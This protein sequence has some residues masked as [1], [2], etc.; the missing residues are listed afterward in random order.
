MIKGFQNKEDQTLE[1]ITGVYGEPSKRTKRHEVI[2]KMNKNLPYLCDK[3]NKEIS[4]LW[5]TLVKDLNENHYCFQCRMSGNKNPNR[6]RSA[7]QRKISGQKAAK[8]RRKNGYYESDVFKQSIK[9]WN[10]AGIK[11]HKE[12]PSKRK[13]LEVSREPDVCLECGKLV[14]GIKQH[15]ATH[16]ISY[17][18]YAI[19]HDIDEL[20]FCNICNKPYI[21]KLYSK[22]ASCSNKECIRLMRLKINR[23]IN[24][25]SETTINRL[26]SMKRNN[27]YGKSKPEET[28]FKFL[29]SKVE[30]ERQIFFK[31]DKTNHVIDFLVKINN[32]NVFIMQDSSYWHGLNRT[33]EEIQKHKNKRDRVIEKIYNKDRYLENFCQENNIN[34]IRFADKLSEPYF[35]CGKS[36]I[37]DAFRE[38]TNAF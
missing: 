27:S 14:S 17:L 37:I 30:V 9:K 4:I 1:N 16:K 3:C 23:E 8:S 6:I 2:I 10:E 25:R 32:E 11:A 12:K 13:Y 28:R 33:F 22:K 35:V 18:D 15:L 20:S 19:K 31:T 34:F 21:K 36:E 7:E 26:S 38:T 29:N 5:T 24:S